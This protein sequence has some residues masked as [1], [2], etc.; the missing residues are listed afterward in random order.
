MKKL[1]ACFIAGAAALGMGLAA[2]Q[3][4]AA[5]EVTNA[6]YQGVIDTINAVDCQAVLKTQRDYGAY[7]ISQVRAVAIAQAAGYQGR[8]LTSREIGMIDGLINAARVRVLACG[9]VVN[10]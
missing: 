6:Q 5:V 7:S 3:A 9:G 10:P 1:K 2:P 8:I 4:H